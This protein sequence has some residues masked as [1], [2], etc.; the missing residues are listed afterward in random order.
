MGRPRL[1]QFAL[2]FL[3]AG[4]VLF[5]F[6]GWLVGMWLAWCSRRWSVR[7]KLIATFCPPFGLYPALWL[8]L[9]PGPA[10]SCTGGMTA[11]GRT[12]ERCTGGGS[13][14]MQAV[15]VAAAIVLAVMPFVTAIYLNR[16]LG[17]PR[18]AP[19]LSAA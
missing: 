12:W 5:P 10:Q 19:R 13:G 6:G 1:E 4:S 14:L 18:R 7:D 15:L 16:R 8:V 3:L 2:F 9:G 11:D 17:P